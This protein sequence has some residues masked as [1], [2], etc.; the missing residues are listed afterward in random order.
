MK[1][2]AILFLALTAVAGCATAPQ[3]TVQTTP[4][5]G[6]LS[7]RI[8]RTCALPESERQVELDKLKNETG[9][10]LYCGKTPAETPASSH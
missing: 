10:V 5:Q 1:A 7:E 3:Q 8:N 4:F 9:F 2:T 6:D